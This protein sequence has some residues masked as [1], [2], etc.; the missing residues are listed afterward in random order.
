MDR[1]FG[2][3]VLN[4]K[5]WILILGGVI[6]AANKKVSVLLSAATKAFE[7]IEKKL[8]ISFLNNI[9]KNKYEEKYNA[10]SIL[11]NLKSNIRS[12]TV[13]NT[14]TNE[15]DETEKLPDEVKEKFASDII[16]KIK[17][18]NIDRYSF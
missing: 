2:I 1:Y 6:M 17:S 4:N 5:V 16:A 13:T 8:A 18:A 11:E 12:S 7:D 9:Q 14:K 3:K 10:D 15:P